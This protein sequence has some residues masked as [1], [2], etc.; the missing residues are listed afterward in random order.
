MEQSACDG[1]GRGGPRVVMASSFMAKKLD[2]LGANQY[3]DEHEEASFWEA[4]RAEHRRVDTPSRRARRLALLA[5]WRLRE[6][7]ASGGG[8]SAV[9]VCPEGRASACRQ[10]RLLPLDSDR[11]RT[12]PAGRQRCGG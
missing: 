6:D 8:E 11:L 2:T 9:A 10:G 4:R 12:E 5:V 3:P 7:A 1:R